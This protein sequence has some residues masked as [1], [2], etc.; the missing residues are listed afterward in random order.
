MCKTC[1]SATTRKC[2]YRRSFNITV[3][4]YDTLLRQQRGRCTICQHV[5]A[6]IRLSVDHDHT[7]GAVRGL[8]CRECN[9]MLG[10]VRDDPTVLRAA[11]TYLEQHKGEK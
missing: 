6:A 9:T 10:M 11:A 2:E 8:L 7:T 1:H 5:H 3:E 4:Q